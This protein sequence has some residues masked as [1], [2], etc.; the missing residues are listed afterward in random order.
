[1]YEWI[2]VNILIFHIKYS[3][4]TNKSMWLATPVWSIKRNVG[5]ISK[6]KTLS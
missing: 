5:K 4:K 1:M 2:V 6:T 3:K